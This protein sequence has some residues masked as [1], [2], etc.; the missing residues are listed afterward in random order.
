M[1]LH[2]KLSHAHP[3]HISI[4][5]NVYMVEVINV[6]MVMFSMVKHV[7][8]IH[9]HVLLEPNGEILIANQ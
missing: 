6:V 7:S 5:I 9:L 3:H 1:D 2:V 4:R 8:Y